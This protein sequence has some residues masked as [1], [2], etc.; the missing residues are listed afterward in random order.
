MKI[1]RPIII[2][3][4]PRSGTTL[5]FSILSSHPDLWSLYTESE[6]IFAKHFHPE[7]YGWSQGNELNAQSASGKTEE[8]MRSELYN[9]VQNYQVFRKN[10]YSKVLVAPIRERANRRLNKHF[11]APFFKPSIIRIVEKTPKNC[12][13]VPFL[14]SMFPD[15]YFVFLTRN[16]RE[17]IS[18]LIE[19]WKEPKKYYTYEVPGGLDIDGYRGNLWNFFLPP[20]WKEYSKGKNLAEVCAFQYR[21]ANEAVLEGLSSVPDERKAVLRYEDLVSSPESQISQVCNRAD[22]SYSGSLRKMAED[23]PVVNSSKQPGPDKWRKNE[24]Q[25]LSAMP[26]VESVSKRMGYLYG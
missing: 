17:N 16:P 20:N 12:V 8:E 3:G 18:S 10:S 23:M 4:A 6:Y 14:N 21:V 15:A 7:K 11:V 5:L 26:S 13:R 19:G 2:L 24:E 25:V 9:Q 1:K 22:L